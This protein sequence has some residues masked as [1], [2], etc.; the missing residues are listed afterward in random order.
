MQHFDAKNEAKNVLKMQHFLG[1]KSCVFVTFLPHFENPKP[2]IGMKSQIFEISKT[3]HFEISKPGTGMK[4]QNWWPKKKSQ[5]C[6]ENE[7]W[8]EK[9]NP[10]IEQ[11]RSKSTQK[12][13]L[14]RKRKFWSRKRK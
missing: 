4:S 8:V 12:S 10:K 7:I 9:E 6:P 3:P 14:E 5:K 11:N 1:L 2:G 13:N